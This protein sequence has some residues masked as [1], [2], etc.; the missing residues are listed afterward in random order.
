MYLAFYASSLGYKLIPNAEI[1][2]IVDVSGAI[3]LGELASAEE[4]IPVLEKVFK[5]PKVKAI[6]LEYR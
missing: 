5:S 1:V 6:A 3:G 4:L 2:A